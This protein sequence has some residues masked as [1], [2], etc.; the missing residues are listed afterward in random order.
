M[1][2][3]ITITTV[4]WLEMLRRKEFYV[5]LIIMGVMLIALLGMD[6]FGLGGVVVYIKDIGLLS[7]WIL[8]WIL[9]VNSGTRQLPREETQ[10]T[11]FTLLAKPVSRFELIIGKW[12]GV[13]TIT[14]LATLSFYLVIVLAVLLQNGHIDPLTMVQGYVLHTA[15]LA[16]IVAFAVA[17]SV[18]LHNDA[19]MVLTYVLTATLYGVI[20]GMSATAM[21]TPGWLGGILT[22]AYF[23]LPHLDVF[24]MRRRIVHDWGPTD[25]A[26]FLAAL[27]YGACMTIAILL[28]AWT[29]YRR[30]R[31][32][33]GALL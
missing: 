15:G 22:A 25:S 18:R 5:L 26:T 17:L 29:A 30:K 24:D 13:W 20:P 28:L 19:A 3:I 7:A 11:I 10:G 1:I 4:V 33:R 31:F 12:A 9:A 2:R 8:A 32:S 27:C 14:A 16:V 21:N 23:L 6:A